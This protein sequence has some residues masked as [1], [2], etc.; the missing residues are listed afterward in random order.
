M[1]KLQAK[2]TD[3]ICRSLVCVAVQYQGS[4]LELHL[5]ILLWHMT[6]PVTFLVLL[7]QE[8]SV[9]WFPCVEYSLSR[10]DLAMDGSNWPVECSLWY[11]PMKI[12]IAITLGSS[13]RNPMP[14][15]LLRYMATIYHHHAPS[16]NWQKTS[17]WNGQ[18]AWDQVEWSEQDNSIF[19]QRC[20]C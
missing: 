1:E 12:S 3:L 13:R 7:S 20:R 4:N 18:L 5:L 11:R 19:Q 6:H 15:V 17:R 14:R 8:K 9:S 2:G 10:G 16:W